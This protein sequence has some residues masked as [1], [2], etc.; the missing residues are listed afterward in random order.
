MYS[1]LLK[2]ALALNCAISFGNCWSSEFFLRIQENCL[3]SISAFLV[4]I[5]LLLDSLLLLMFL[6]MLMYS[7][8]HSSMALQ[9]FVAPWPLLQFHNRFYTDGRTPWTSDQPVARPLPTQRKTQTQNK[10][11]QTSMP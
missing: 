7:L 10:R 9:P 4:E 6:G 8:I 5:V 1:S 2:F 11:T 3:C